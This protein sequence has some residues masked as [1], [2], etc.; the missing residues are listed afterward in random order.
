MKEHSGTT[1]R[2]Y[3][4]RPSGFYNAEDLDSSELQSPE[5]HQRKV[6]ETVARARDKIFEVLREMPRPL[7]DTSNSGIFDTMFPMEE[8]S[9]SFSASVTAHDLSFS[10]NQ[11]FPS[12]DY[13]KSLAESIFESME[14]HEEKDRDPRLDAPKFL[15]SDELYAIYD[16]IESRWVEVCSKL[17]ASLNSRYDQFLADCRRCLHSEQRESEREQ[18]RQDMVEARRELLLGM[19]E[20]F[21]AMCEEYDQWRVGYLEGEL[22]SSCLALRQKG[23]SNVL[24]AVLRF[25]ILKGLPELEQRTRARAVAL[26]KELMEQM[27]PDEDAFQK[28]LA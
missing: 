23:Q 4:D 6:T 13:T 24:A 28:K 2:R 17:R 26:W 3:A 12:M 16:H 11:T 21:R 9:Q 15:V 25:E 27:E 8:M 22:D 19:K 5:S 7:A 20:E 1:P 14:A 10:A 18:L